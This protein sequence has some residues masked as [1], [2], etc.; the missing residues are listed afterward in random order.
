M[1]KTEGKESI[2]TPVEKGGPLSS[3]KPG[4]D[5]LVGQVLGTVVYLPSGLDYARP[6]FLAST[7]T[8]EIPVIGGS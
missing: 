3:L 8:H 5:I 6:P 7:P 2:V 1:F 4:R